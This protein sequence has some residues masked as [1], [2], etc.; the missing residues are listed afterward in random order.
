MMPSLGPARASAPGT[1][2]PAETA[3]ASSPPL[4]G[5]ALGQPSPAEQGIDFTALSQMYPADESPIDWAQ[6]DELLQEHQ[7]QFSGGN[8]FGA[9]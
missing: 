4:P 5:D 6:W 7:Q 3:F 9:A 2:A 8:L 1:I